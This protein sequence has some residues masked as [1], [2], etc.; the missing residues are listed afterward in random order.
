MAAN[1]DSPGNPQAAGDEAHVRRLPFA[2]AK[3]HGVLLE[4]LHDGVLQA[5][6]RSGAAPQSLA[7]VRRF[8]GQRV[9]FREVDPQAFDARAGQNLVFELTAG[10][11]TRRRSFGSSTRC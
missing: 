4:D 11:T 7:E 5:I 2:F 9:A 6:Y 8:A 10:S 3:R 1:L